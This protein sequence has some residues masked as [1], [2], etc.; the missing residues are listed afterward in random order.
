MTTVGSLEDM[1]ENHNL[2]TIARLLIELKLYIEEGSEAE[3][4]LNEIRFLL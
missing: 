1:L 3:R 4:K 2:L